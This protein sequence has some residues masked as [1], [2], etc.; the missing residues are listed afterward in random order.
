MDIRHEI[1]VVLK[2]YPALVHHLENNSLSGELFLPDGD[3]YEILIFLNN[4]PDHFPIVIETGGRIPKKLDR[5]IYTDRGSC[6]FTTAA[7]AQILLRTKIT[8]L[9][10]FID[11]IVIRYFQNNSFYELNNKYCFEEYE[12]GALGVVQSYQDI[13]GVKSLSVIVKLILQRL[14]NSKLTLRDLCFCNSG[15]SLKKCNSGLHCKNYRTFR[16]IDK[17]VLFNDLDHFKNVLNMLNK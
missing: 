7:K 5:H 14:K 9:V 6:C 12:H 3:S 16:M 8:S 4:Y 2:K 10:K 11:E 15:Q 1:E 13:L 17:S